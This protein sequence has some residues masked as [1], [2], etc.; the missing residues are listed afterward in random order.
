MPVGTTTAREV[1]SPRLRGEG[2]GEGAV[3]K[4]TQ[5]FEQGRKVGLLSPTLSS[6][7]GEGVPPAPWWWYQA[8]PG[9]SEQ[10]PL[11]PV[12]V[13]AG[14]KGLTQR[15]ELFGRVVAPNLR[16]FSSSKLVAPFV[17]RVPD[18][19]FEPLP[20]DTVVRGGC[21]ELPP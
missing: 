3:R 20:G 14:N 5:R 4:R 8:A 7:G 19:A 11:I 6:R 2:Q 12:W 1:P 17:I 10:I 16:N 9:L 15:G 13:T 18:M 21:F